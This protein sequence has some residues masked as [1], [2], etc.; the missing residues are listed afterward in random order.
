MQVSPA[1]SK[2]WFYKYRIQNKEKQLALGSYPTVSLT[3][4]RKARDIAKLKKSEGVDPIQ[5]RK[6]EKLK[7]LA[8]DGSVFKVVAL[9]W[10]AKQV[11]TWSASHAER[12]KR[13]LERDLFPWIGERQMESIEPMELLPVSASQLVSVRVEGKERDAKQVA[14]VKR[15]YL[16]KLNSHKDTAQAQALIVVT[17]ESVSDAMRLNVEQALAKAVKSPSNAI[18]T[19]PAYWLR[20]GWQ[21]YEQ[22]VAQT[23]VIQQTANHKLQVPCGRI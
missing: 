6:M 5:A 20:G 7:G 8:V 3:A 21:G 19:L 17:D 4:A 9:E 2:R 14:A 15:V 1:G 23:A 22:Q 11:G 18:A 12:T 10:H 16:E 13:Q